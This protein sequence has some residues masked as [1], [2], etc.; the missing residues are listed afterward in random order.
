MLKPSNVARFLAWALIALS[1]PF[2]FPAGSSAY[3]NGGPLAPA[4][5]SGALST[6]DSPESVIDADILAQNNHDWSRFLQLRSANPKAPENVRDWTMLRA[7]HPENDF[8]RNIVSAKRIG[9]H[10]LA[11]VAAAPLTR[12]GEYL[13][14]YGEVKVFYVGIEYELKKETRAFYDGVN[15]RLYVLAPEAGRWV[16]VEASEAPVRRLVEEGYGFRTAEERDAESVQL[17]RERSGRFYSPR[18]ALIDAVTTTDH[19]QPNHI[20]VYLTGSRDGNITEID[21]YDYVTNVLPNEWYPT[22]PLASL[23]AGAISAKMYGWYRV[24]YSKYPGEGY[25]VRDDADDQV[26]VAGSAKAST[27]AAVDAVQ[28]ASFQRSD[29]GLFE[30]QYWDGT[31]VVTS[32]YDLRSAPGPSSPV[33]ANGHVSA[34]AQLVILSNGTT[35]LDGGSTYWWQVKTGGSENWTN[36]VVGWIPESNLKSTLTFPIYIFRGRMGQWGTRYWAD[37]TNPSLNK[38]Y[39]WISHYFY[40]NSPNANDQPIANFAYTP[41]RSPDQPTNTKPVDGATQISLSPLLCGSPFSDPDSGDYH[42]KTLWHITRASDGGLV[43]DS[44][45]RTYDLTGTIVPASLLDYNTTYKWQVRYMDNK[46][47]WSE[48]PSTTTRFTTSPNPAVLTQSFLPYL[49]VG[50]FQSRPYSSYSL[51][52]PVVAYSPAPPPTCP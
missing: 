5:M 27:T 39:D 1:F 13:A 42:W 32:Q 52:L 3:F 47:A 22:W 30:P 36:F 7:K 35:T 29:G 14:L 28:G 24:Y 20:S 19:A 26:Y 25:D 12:L 10:E 18:G 17:E 2:L 8:M 33:M 6:G 50:Q 4:P 38:G 43:W 31:A 46:G 44:G 21:F 11:L 37:P 45:W 48:P 40:D 15:Y 49:S 51:Y 41:N 16:I 9:I 23:E 34:G